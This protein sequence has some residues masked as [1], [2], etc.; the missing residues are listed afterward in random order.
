MVAAQNFYVGVADSGK[1]NANERPTV[2][3]FRQ[4]LA[5]GSECVISCDEGEHA[6]PFLLA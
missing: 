6:R 2:P 5:G 4:G 3:K 1:S